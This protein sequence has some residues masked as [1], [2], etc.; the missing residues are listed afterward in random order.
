MTSFK[1]YS[2][3]QLKQL[4]KDYNI[5]HHIK[6]YYK[7]SKP[8]LIQ[9]IEKHLTHDE[10]DTIISINGFKGEIKYRNDKVQLK[11]KELLEFMKLNIPDIIYAMN[12]ILKESRMKFK[13]YEMLQEHLGD[14]S[15]SLIMKLLEKYD[16][17]LKLIYNTI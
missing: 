3:S 15:Y 2:K 5:H 10:D 7:M 6:G 4:I 16:M 14:V 12:V 8:L 17:P 13:E 9:H 11:K 1:Y